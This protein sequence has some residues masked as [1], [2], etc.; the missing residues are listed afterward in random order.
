MTLPR[1]RRIA[2]LALGLVFLAAAAAFR[3]QLALKPDSRLWIDGG[4]TLRDW[5]CRATQ[6]DAT[7]DGDA[8]APAE[9]LAGR[10]AVRAVQLTIPTARLDC[11]NR[12][13]NGHML[14]ALHADDH[15]TIVFS[16]ASYDVVRASDVTGTLQGSLT[17]NGQARPVTLP[18][19][20]APVDGALR[21]T[22]SYPL[23]MTDW[24][25]EPPKLMLGTLKVKPLVTVNFDFVLQPLVQP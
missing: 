3:G 16:L 13:M 8:T 22:G 5:S 17:I 11:D 21:V 14:K 7:I 1:I 24:G 15:P 18:V 25:V 12:T 10:K 19:T 20:F 6:L 2:P 23:T 9:V 4:S